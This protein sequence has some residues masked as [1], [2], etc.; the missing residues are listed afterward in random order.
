MNVIALAENLELAVEEIFS[1]MRLFYE[2]S[3]SDFRI[4]QEAWARGSALEVAQAAHSIKG[5]AINLGLQG[6]HKVAKEI[7][8][9]A[10]QKHLKEVEKSLP[11]LRERLNRLGESIRNRSTRIP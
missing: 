11:V 9:K 3:L 4:M 10:R 2:N 5:G 6:I 1:L 7:E 8:T